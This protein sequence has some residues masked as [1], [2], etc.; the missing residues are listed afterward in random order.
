MMKAYYYVFISVS[1]LLSSCGLG[2]GVLE[3]GV[4]GPAGGYVFYDKG[5]YSDGWR[6]LECAPEKVGG[7]VYWEE[8]ESVCEDYRLGG[9]DD[10]RLPT[11]TELKLMYT[12][13]HEKHMGNFKRQ[14]HDELYWSSASGYYLN[15]YDGTTSSYHFSCYVRPV[16]Q[17]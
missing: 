6:Y 7:E 13:L 3:G 17:F 4:P 14:D 16:R 8:A 12:N 9:Y 2:G 5:S 10:W 1:V 11:A 15:F